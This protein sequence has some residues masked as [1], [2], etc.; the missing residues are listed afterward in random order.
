MVDGTQTP[1]KEVLLLH[2]SRPGYVLVA[3]DAGAEASVSVH[4][5]VGLG[6]AMPGVLVCLHWA[7]ALEVN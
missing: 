4:N 2:L 7:S 6:L 3:R 1:D 5:S